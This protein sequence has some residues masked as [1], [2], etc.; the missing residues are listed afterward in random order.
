MRKKPWLVLFLLVLVLGACSQPTAGGDGGDDGSTNV[1]IEEAYAP[2][3]ATE[4]LLYQSFAAVGQLGVVSVPPAFFSTSPLAVNGAQGFGWTCTG[5]ASSGDLTDPDHDGIPT[6]AHYTGQCTVS[7]PQSGTLNWTLDFYIADAGN[8]DP[9]AGFRSH[10]SVVW[11]VVGQGKLTWTITRHDVVRQAGGGAYDLA[12]EGEWQFVDYQDSSNDGSIAYDLSGT[13]TPDD[14]NASSFLDLWTAG[15]L[16]LGG[17]MTFSGGGCTTS[18]SLQF[19]LHYDASG[20]ADRGSVS[21]NGQDCSGSSCSFTASWSSCGGVPT[22]S[23]G[24]SP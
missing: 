11:E 18:A 6:N 2:I 7:D 20:C 1:G 24:C 16:D 15:T 19:N 21:Y 12:Y 4:S 23:G 17:S 9:L 13:W 8:G 10:G 3:D 22:I 5:V 14:P